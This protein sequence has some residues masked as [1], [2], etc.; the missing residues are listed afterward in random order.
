M[1]DL[2]GVEEAL[3]RLRRGEGARTV[4]IVDP[5]LARRHTMT[6]TVEDAV[7]RYIRSQAFVDGAYVDAASTATTFD[8]VSPAT[9]RAIAPG[10]RVRR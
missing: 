6:Q 9:G 10:R 8:C 7:T 5:D 4:V 3:G 1:T 2:D